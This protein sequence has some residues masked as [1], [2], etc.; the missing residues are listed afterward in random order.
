MTQQEK[1]PRSLP[2]VLLSFVS[3]LLFA[4]GLAI[5]GMTQPS[6]VVGFLDND[7]TTDFAVRVLTSPPAS[8]G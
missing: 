4:V 8:S 7:F 1:K 3:G 6:K 5:A 2:E